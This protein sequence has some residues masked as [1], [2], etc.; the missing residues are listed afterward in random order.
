[1]AHWP[2]LHAAQEILEER[3][4]VGTWVNRTYVYHQRGK[5]RWCHLPDPSDRDRS[6]TT[7]EPKR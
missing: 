3:P 5:E 2:G 1:M 4:L 6:I 7:V